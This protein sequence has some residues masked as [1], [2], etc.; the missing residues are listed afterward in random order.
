MKTKINW[1]LA[2]VDVLRTYPNAYAVNV[3]TKEG[4]KF[5]HILDEK[6]VRPNI[7]GRGKSTKNAWVAA[8]RNIN[9]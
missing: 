7:I 6:L 2:K 9:R 8:F 5:Y 4:G 3:G 1:K